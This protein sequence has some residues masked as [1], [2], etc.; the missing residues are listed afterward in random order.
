[1]VVGV[2]P[3]CV[4]RIRPLAHAWRIAYDSSIMDGLTDDISI[5]ERGLLGGHAGAHRLIT[6]ITPVIQRRVA[7]AGVSAQTSEGTQRSD[8]GPAV[9]DRVATEGGDVF[10]PIP[11]R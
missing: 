3:S 8:Q 9:I 5:L 10:N 1:M 2:H 11:L 4:F 6:Y 7:W